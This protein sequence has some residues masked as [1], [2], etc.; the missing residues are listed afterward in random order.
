MWIKRSILKILIGILVFLLIFGVIRN[1]PFY[2][3]QAV[4]AGGLAEVL[5]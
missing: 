2:P 4:S 1:L 3:F 5:M